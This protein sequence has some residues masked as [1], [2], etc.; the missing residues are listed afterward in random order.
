MLPD[1]TPRANEANDTHYIE[2]RVSIIQTRKIKPNA[3]DI[4]ADVGVVGC[5]NRAPLAT[6]TCGALR[7]SRLRPA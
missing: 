6:P 2:L 5:C 4:M 1:D 3:F 7:R